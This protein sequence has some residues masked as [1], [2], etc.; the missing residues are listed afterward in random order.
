MI[1]T[2]TSFSLILSLFCLSGCE[3][4]QPE[5]VLDNYT[6]RLS[7]VLDVQHELPSAPDI[8]VFPNRRDRIIATLEIR[9]GLLDVL[10]LK[11]CNL[12]P[13][14][15]ERNSSLGKVYSASQKLV[16]ELKFYVAIRNCLDDLKNDQQADSK[17]LKQV[18]EIYQTKHANLPAEIWNGVYTSKELERNFSI[19]EAPLPLQ[20]DGT[21][22]SMLEAY[23]ALTSLA[24]LS[25][26]ET[27]W[28][29]PDF[30][31]NIELIYEQLHR[32]R[33]GAKILTSL[34]LV[35]QYLNH[36]SNLIEHHLAQKPICFNGKI[37]QKAK[38]LQNV[39]Y[40][41]YAAE[42]QPYLVHVHKTAQAWLDLNNNF[43][44]NLT[45]Q[46]LVL[47][48]TVTAYQRR[49]IARNSELSLWSEYEA[50][51]TRHIKAWQTILKQCGM[52]PS[53]KASLDKG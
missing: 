11:Q 44:A 21:S 10:K 28:S 50:S 27:P 47:Q 23:T 38:I 17:L 14:I 18:T 46:G 2:L 16:Y 29:L 52:M 34:K 32:N 7:R 41:Y 36:A 43:I 31:L 24:D 33:S 48:P 35:T 15:A 37:N 13:L 8:P 39:F 30:V 49:I 12:L 9:E 3:N 19:G 5:D 40:K 6:S 22:A 45:T 42:F 25:A 20:A 26:D 51:R 4:D 53:Q 1:K